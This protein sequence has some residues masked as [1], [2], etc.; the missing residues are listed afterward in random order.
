MVSE[1]M[2]CKSGAG[3][4]IGTMLYDSMDMAVPNSRDSVE[5]YPTYN[6]A[7]VALAKGTYTPRLHP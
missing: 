3:Y 4:Y 1:L 2:V 7:E 5:Y 6:D